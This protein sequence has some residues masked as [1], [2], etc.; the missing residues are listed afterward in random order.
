MSSIKKIYWI[1]WIA[2]PIDPRSKIKAWIPNLPVMEKLVRLDG[3]ERVGE[4]LEVVS[5]HSCGI[6]LD[7][8]GMDEEEYAEVAAAL[9]GSHVNV[10]SFHYGRTSTVSLQEWQLFESQLDLVVERAK[11]FECSVVSVA[12]PRAEIN[13]SHTVRDLQDFMAEADLYCK[14]AELEVCFLLDGFMKDPEMMNTALAGL[15]SPSIGVMV[16]LSLL[17]N[18][19]DP[20]QIMDRIDV[21]MRKLRMPVPAGE[22]DEHLGDVESDVIVVA[23]RI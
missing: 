16:D 18:G 4:F 7:M 12:P 9:D 3:A 14:N 21:R 11:R 2:A 13:E 8:T 23:E 5:R 19:V 1:T 17:V 6:E 15:E 20:I 22:L 10:G